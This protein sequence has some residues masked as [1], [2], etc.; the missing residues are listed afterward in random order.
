MGVFRRGRGR[1]A[2]IVRPKPAI[3]KTPIEGPTIVRMSVE[4]ELEERRELRRKARLAVLAALR[5]VGGEGKRAELLSRALL[6]GGFTERELAAPAPEK[7]R[8]KY[9]RH[10]DYE[11]AWTFTNLKRDGLIS[12]PRWG[13]WALAGAAAEPPTLMVE[14]ATRDRLGELRAMPYREYLRTP[15][16]RATR[17]AALARAGFA[18]AL[19]SSHTQ[20]LEVHHRTYERLGQEIEADLTVLCEP[21]HDLHHKVN[22]RPKRERGARTRSVPPPNVARPHTSAPAERPSLLK[23]LLG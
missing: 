11:L 12:N 17:A 16:W 15:E 2:P 21:C 20:N 22:G 13:V 4:L 18:C 5:S 6:E 9:S 8:D 3:L 14:P 23:R 19:D 1:Q 10:L 7:H